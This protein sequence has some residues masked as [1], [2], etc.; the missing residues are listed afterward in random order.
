VSGVET[1]MSM[2]T[3]RSALLV[4]A[5]VVATA[6]STGGSSS[7]TPT[8]AAS[9]AQTSSPTVTGIAHPTGPGEIVLRLD[10]SGGFVPPEFLAAHVPQ[11]TLYGDGTVV[12][13]AM[14]PSRPARADNV[15]VGEP[16]RTAKLSED[17]VQQLLEYA[18]RDGRLGVAK[19]EYQNPLV[20]DAAT[21][22]FT[23]DADGA[24]K[25]VSVVAL[26]MEDPEL[27]PDTEIK[28]SLAAL[29]NRLR[30][31]DLGGTIAASPYEPEA[32]RGILLEQEGLEGVTVRDWP[33]SD[34]SPADFA[35][36]QDPNVL[37]HGTAVL[38][39]E[40]AATLGVDGFENG[41]A[42]GVFLRD[43]AGKVYSF[44]LRPLLPDEQP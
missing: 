20:A 8:G 23:L 42:S 24:K 34:L 17:Q 32:Y 30:D 21:A 16:I 39:Q 19:A 7:S 35:M 22:V 26:G 37:Q 3:R 15:S 36:P 41:I 43:D 6:C 29:G 28:H 31:F 5:L 10:E 33:W 25:T 4:L 1:P 40:Q 2:P 13:T 12:F 44:V 14:E 27:T 38:A 18:I 9:P 11:F